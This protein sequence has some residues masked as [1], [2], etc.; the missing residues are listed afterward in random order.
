MEAGNKGLYGCP[1]F[2]LSE[3]N[4][5]GKPDAGITVDEKRNKYR[6]GTCISDLSEGMCRFD[7]DAGVLIV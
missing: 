7:P 6:S 2:D 3:G 4:H 1:V 5:S